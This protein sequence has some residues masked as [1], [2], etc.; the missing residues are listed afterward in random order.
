MRTDAINPKL[1]DHILAALMPDNETALRISLATGLRI[2][3]VLALRTEQLIKAKNNKLT[4]RERKTGK[5]KRIYMP[6]HLLRDAL[7]RSGEIYV[8][9]HRTDGRRHRTRQAVWKDI[10]RAA[11]LFRIS[12]ALTIAPHSARKIYACEAFKKTGDMRKVQALLNHADA[13]T[14]ALYIMAEEIA[15]KKTGGKPDPRRE[16]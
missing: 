9:P 3:D 2:D 1:F 5:N 12:E 4:V 15:K 16:R 13:T 14:T 7:R 8:F 10:K 11:K 6:E